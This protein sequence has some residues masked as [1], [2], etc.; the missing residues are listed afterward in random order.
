MPI[1]VTQFYAKIKDLPRLR[2]NYLMTGKNT[3]FRLQ[4]Q[5]HERYNDLKISI[6]CL[7][8]FLVISEQ[9]GIIVILPI[10]R[11]IN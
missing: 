2:L 11:K 10:P 1:A 6:I 4:K 5:H 8:L 3:G 7:L 9:S